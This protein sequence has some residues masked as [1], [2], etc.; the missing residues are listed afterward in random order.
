MVA[1]D[2]EGRV[3]FG[4]LHVFAVRGGGCCVIVGGMGGRGVWC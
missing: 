2:V 4:R 3:R 1:S